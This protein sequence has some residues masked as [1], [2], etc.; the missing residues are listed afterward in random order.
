MFGHEPGAGAAHDARH[1]HLGARARYVYLW[2]LPLVP[3]ALTAWLIWSR[4]I[5]YG[6]WFATSQCIAW[7]LGTLSYYAL[8]TLG[9]GLQYV[10]LYTDLPEHRRRRS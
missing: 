7:A 10:P 8:P 6:Y 9:P 3:L 5:T 2:F 1:R 4:N